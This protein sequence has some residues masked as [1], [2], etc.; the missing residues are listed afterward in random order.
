MRLHTVAIGGLTLSLSAS[1]LAAKQSETNSIV[2]ESC[3][4]TAS[5]PSAFIDMMPKPEGS[6]RSGTIVASLTVAIDNTKGESLT[7]SV[8]G[9]LVD[10][11]GHRV[12]ATWLEKDNQKPWDGKIER[13]KKQSLRLIARLNSP[14]IKAGSSVK[15]VVVV[16]NKAGNRKTMTSNQV[17]IIGAM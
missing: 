4:L 16:I 13:G 10:A 6:K 11:K 17:R 7:L 3:T 12:S 14:K 15:M 9:A 1:A 5:H 2:V 8:D